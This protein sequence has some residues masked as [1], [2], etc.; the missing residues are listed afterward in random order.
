MRLFGAVA[1]ASL[2][3][4]IVANV[5]VEKVKRGPDWSDVVAL[6]FVI[7]PGAIFI[8]SAIGLLLSLTRWTR[9][10]VVWVLRRWAFC[11]AALITLIALFYAEENWRG[12]RAWERSK[13]QLEAQGH[14]LDWEKFIPPPVPDDQ[15]FFKAPHM[16]EWFVK[17]NRGSTT[18]S[19]TARLANRKTDSIGTGTNA[20]TTV[21]EAKEYLDW[22]SQFDSDFDGIR[23]AL[24]RPHFRIDDEYVMPYEISIPNFI[25]MRAI[26]RTL[27][28]RAHCYLLLNE[29][30]KAA[31]ELIF[32]RDLCQ[33][34]ERSK[35]MTLVGAMI[36]VAVAGLYTE[37]IN[38]GFRSHAWQEPQLIALQRQLANTHLLP[39]VFAAMETEP[40]ASCRSFERLGGKLF[41]S[42]SNRRSQPWLENRMLSLWP[43]GWTYQ[44]MANTAPLEFKFLQGVN[45]SAE[46]VS[47]TELQEGS[48]AVER[49]LASSPL[50]PY[51]LMAAMA[52]PNFTKAW[53]TT[54]RNQTFVNEA[55]IACALERYRLA[56]GEYPDSLD[57]L[58]PQFV[59][60][61]PHDVING[62]PLHYRRT[63]DGKFLLYSVGWNE[64]D[65]GGT[66]VMSEGKNP[67]VDFTKGDWVWKFSDR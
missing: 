23:A 14:V 55:Q 48:K 19:L 63:A 66:V 1:L 49:F 59:E 47:P 43:N 61:I 26:A 41:N 34:L 50:C 53:Q 3:F 54:A 6:T 39:P 32:L 17:S 7:V 29:P 67:A 21:A 20:I 4:T 25:S 58:V 45:V 24:K 56:H 64:K 44:N 51:K 2:V 18:N 13:Q 9:P 62:Q 42:L 31:Q 8:L 60:T 37:T 10:L 28:Q 38:D 12:R 65:D 40:A 36:N 57:A 5:V 33:L 52:I 46:T 35:P 30:D 11:L 16:T 15:N 27:A 22:S